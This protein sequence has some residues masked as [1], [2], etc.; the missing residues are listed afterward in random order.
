MEEL[1]PSASF[2]IVFFDGESE[3]DIGPITVH[4]S[5]SFKRFLT[6]ISQKIGVPEHRISTSL[7]RRK[8]ARLSPE[9]RRK[10]PID[11]SS[12]FAG[13]AR[14]RDC[15][16]LALLKKSRR[17]RSGRRGE[18]YT[19]QTTILK[20]NHTAAG[21]G[22]DPPFGLSMSSSALWDVGRHLQNLERQRERYLL[23]TASAYS[24]SKPPAPPS[25]LYEAWGV[26]VNPVPPDPA[27][28]EEC[29]GAKKG[30]QAPAFHWCVYD[31]VT[32]AFR[33]AVGPIQRPAKKHIEASA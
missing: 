4:P 28:C 15:F 11:E 13:I 22:D 7:V 9:I 29:L 12:D 30:G 25:S 23:S 3:I 19:E 1:A 2:P 24:E 6:L 17:T 26:P 27:V 16:V 18:I 21:S 32:V 20:R 8:K 5:L 14:E 10:V 33:S 31:A